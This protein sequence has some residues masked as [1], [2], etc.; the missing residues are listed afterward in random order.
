MGAPIT[1]FMVPQPMQERIEVVTTIPD[2]SIHPSMLQYSTGRGIITGV[3]LTHVDEQYEDAFDSSNLPKMLREISGLPIEMLAELIGVSRNAYQKWLRSG[4]VKPE[5][6]AQLTKMLDTF[7]TLRNLRV[8]DLQSF[9]VN[10]G[11]SGKPLDLLAAGDIQA[12]IGLALRAASQHKASS[13]ISAEARQM[14]GIAG[15]V[16]PIKKLNWQN[17]R[18]EGNEQEDALDRLSPRPIPGEVVIAN[19]DNDEDQ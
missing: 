11:P 12:V 17:S 5:H 19:N 6:V 4:G 10:V 15:W 9:L 3:S 1:S 13:L 14:S 8:R 16:R 2:G 18:L 7:Q